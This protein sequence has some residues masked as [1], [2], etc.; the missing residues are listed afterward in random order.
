MGV[1]EHPTWQL[2]TWRVNGAD[3]KAAW[4]LLTPA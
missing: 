4:Q 3:Y 2:K 1:A